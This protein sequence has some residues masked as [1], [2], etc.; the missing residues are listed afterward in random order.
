MVNRL[1]EENLRQKTEKQ[2]N[3]NKPASN[4]IGGNR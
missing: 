2:D 1:N 4:I 3:K